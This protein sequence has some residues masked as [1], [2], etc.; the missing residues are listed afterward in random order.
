MNEL[1]YRDARIAL[2]TKITVIESAR[3][4]MWEVAFDLSSLRFCSRDLGLSDAHDAKRS[5]DA[6]QAMDEPSLYS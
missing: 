1:I 6:V 5:D 2:H 3:L 4:P